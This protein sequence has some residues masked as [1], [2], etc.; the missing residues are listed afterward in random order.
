MTGEG[1]SVIAIDDT[2][3]IEHGHDPEQETAA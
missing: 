3:R 2:V 1:A